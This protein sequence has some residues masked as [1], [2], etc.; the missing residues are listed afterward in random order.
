MHELSIAAAVVELACRHATGRRVR[1][2]Q[3]RVGWLRQVVPEALSFSFGLMAETS[4]LRGAA[5]EIEMVPAV[6]RCRSCGAETTL[7]SF[8]LACGV[9]G[10]FGLDILRGDELLVESL[11]LEEVECGA[12]R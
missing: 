8:P 6:G 7:E 11:D 5:L 2:V 1:A 9:C 4:A 12:R 10:G 3:I